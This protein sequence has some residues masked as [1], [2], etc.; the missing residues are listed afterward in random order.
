MSLLPPRVK[1]PQGDDVSELSTNDTLAAILAKLTE[2]VTAKD[3]TP[4]ILKQVLEENRRALDAAEARRKEE[5]ALI[6]AR[7]NVSHPDVSAFNPLGERDH[8][9]PRF[10]ARK[11]YQ[12][13][14]ELWWEQLTTEEIELIN[15]LPPGKSRVTKA[16]GSRIAFEVKEFTTAN[17]DLEK[18][19]IWYQTKGEHMQNHRGLVDYMREYLGEPDERTRHL[20]EIARLR[21][22][23]EALQPVRA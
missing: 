20:S 3:S 17:G 8:P 21:A 22:E 4:E 11:V 5:D 16:D 2:A 18:K 13:G 19:E 14:Y 15:K 12:N 23:L 6:M 7:S 10:I 1:K 9:R